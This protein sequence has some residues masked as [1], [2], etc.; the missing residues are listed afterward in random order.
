[1]GA[2]FQQNSCDSKLL[3][4]PELM[5]DDIG[6][7]TR[8]FARRECLEIKPAEPNVSDGCIHAVGS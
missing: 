3:A 4:Q 2:A 8:T 6:N 7:C 1:M 5:V